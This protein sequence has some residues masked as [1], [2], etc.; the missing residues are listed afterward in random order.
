MVSH[1]VLFRP[2]PNLTE[3]DRQALADAL[4]RALRTI[5]SVRR[6][7]LG[8]R[9]THGRGYESAMAED[10]SFAA[11]IEFDDLAGLQAY[12]RHPAHEALGARFRDL[13]EAGLIY[14]FE[15]TD[16]S[17]VERLLQTARQARP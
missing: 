4:D 17:G 13:V 3:N 10:L 16:L 1:I 12:L 7:R 14:D 8:R 2:R 15:M 6:V 9:I 11:V 5:P